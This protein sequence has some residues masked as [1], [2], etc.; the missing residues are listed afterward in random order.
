MY[1]RTNHQCSINCESN[2]TCLST[3]LY[4]YA[5]SQGNI[6]TDCDPGSCSQIQYFSW[7]FSPTSAPS[8]APT[9]SPSTAPTSVPSS[10]PT[11]PPTSAPT[12]SPSSSP[13]LS[14][15]TQPTTCYD[16]N[17]TFTND[18]YE[19]PIDQKLMELISYHDL[20]IISND[21]IIFANET[22]QYKDN[23][24]NF[25]DDNIQQLKCTEFGACGGAEI[26]FTKNSV[27]VVHCLDVLSCFDAIININGCINTNIICDGDSACT[28]MKILSSQI[29]YNNTISI[30]C[31]ITE[32]CDNVN[33]TITGNSIT[34][35]SCL[36]INACDD[37]NIEIDPRNYKQ[38]KLNLYAYSNRIIF[39]NGFGFEEIEGD[40]EQYI[41]CNTRDKYFEYPIS[42]T[43]ITPSDLDTLVIS[44]YENG[45]FPCDGVEVLC[46]TNNSSST[47][48]SCKMEKNI[49][50]NDINIDSSNPLIPCYWVPID[51]VTRL[52]CRGNCLSSPTESPTPAPTHAPST[53]TERPT[54]DP[55]KN[56]SKGPTLDPTASPSTEPTID[57]TREP[58]YDPTNAPSAAPSRIPT[59]DVDLIYDVK[60]EMDFT[61]HN[62]TQQ[63]KEE[64]VT[65]TDEIITSIIGIIEINYFDE[66]LGLTYESYW[67]IVY[68]ID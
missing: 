13:S 50:N 2:Q 24:L 58:T 57:P 66:G 49:V 40:Y 68:E 14:P 18:G 61:Y 22:I 28:N 53:P 21:K 54:Y 35:I 32:S 38:A 3:N 59:Q 26:T 51:N 46:Y 48:S 62:L 55:T 11:F 6:T 64:L 15:T 41:T 9:T 36:G 1:C 45:L 42:D 39:N 34:E 67:V 56:P 27:C 52:S 25:T 60:I 33:V 8:L 17:G 12:I 29:G 10:A 20:L 44:K 19:Q 4:T 31:G 5:G 43:I 30:Y 7:S 63:N 37:M 16:L 47:A 65:N 23:I